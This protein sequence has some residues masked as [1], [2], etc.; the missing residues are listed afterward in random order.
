MGVHASTAKVLARANYPGD[1][2]VGGINSI[3]GRDCCSPFHLY[4]VL[5]Y[6]DLL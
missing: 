6:E 3:D 4:V 2:N 5:V 1:V